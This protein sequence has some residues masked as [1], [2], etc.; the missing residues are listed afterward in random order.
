LKLLAAGGIILGLGSLGGFRFLI[1]D[2]RHL[3]LAQLASGQTTGGSWSL[4]QNTTVLAIHAAITSTG[5]ILYIAGS[6]WCVNNAT[7][8]YTARLL[9]PVTGS[10]TNVTGQ[11]SDLFC[12]GLTH[13]SNGN[14]FICGGTKLYDVDVSSCNGKWH[15]ANSAYEFDIPSGS[16][17]QQGIQ[18]MAQGRWYPTCVTL[19]N[20]KVLIVGGDDDYGDQNYITE[21]YDPSTKSI[22]ISYDPTSNNT[23]CVG[24]IETSS[25]PG[26]GKPCYGGPNQG[27]GPWLSL[28][29]RMH[30]MPS[31]LVF[32]AGPTQDTYL[33]DQFNGSWTHVN[34]TLQFRDYGTTFLLPLQ[35]TTTERGKVMIV[36]GSSTDTTTATNVVEMED[37]NQGTSTNPVLRTVSSITYA[38]KYPLPIIL[39]DGK[40]VIF[41]GSSQGTTN[42][43]LIP[44]MF[45]PENESAG[46]VALPAATVPR[47]YHGMGMLLPDGSVWTA[48]S[49]QASCSTEY[50]TEIFK[51]AYF[52]STRPTI[53]GAPTVGGYGQSIT[54]PTPDA[55]S[56]TRVSLLRLAA[57]THHYDANARLIWLQITGRTSS[58][59]T[60]SA[61]INA[62]LAPPGYYMIYVLN[63]S[64]LVPSVAKIIQIPGSAGGGSTTPPGQ[65]TGLTVTPVSGTY[66]LNLAWTANA[67]TDN[68]I[69]YNVYRST[70]SGFTVN[71]ATD[72]P[73]A[74]PATNS[75]SDAGLTTSTTYYYRVAAVNS[76]GIIGPVSSQASGTTVA[77][78]TI[79]NVQITSPANGATLPSGN[80]LVQGTASDDPGGSGINNVSVRYDVDA[81][82][83]PYATATPSAPGNWSTWSI[84]L[85]ITTAGSHTILA[86]ATDNSGNQQWYEIT[87]TT[88][89]GGTTAPGQVTGLAVTPVSSTQLNLAWTAN[90]STDNVT[91]Y[92]VYRS[93]TSGF[94]VNTATDTPIA[95]PA[96]N[97][98]S[99]AGLTAST[100]YYYR[101]AAVNSSGVIGT[102]SNI[103][104]GTT[105]GTTPPPDTTAPTVTITSP[106]SG[107]SLP[108]GS[109]LVK[110]TAADNTGGSGVN[111]V[112]V[113]VDAGALATATPFAPGNWS[114][115]SVTVTITTTGQH[116]IVAKATDNAGNT[117]SS[118]QVPIK[119][120]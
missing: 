2:K 104:S 96:T 66:K 113:Q 71:T 88:T 54:I 10:E 33:W 11:N 107:S 20:G 111:T 94:T 103:A 51:P 41:A 59:I 6:G 116:K 68:V 63:G 26:A 90:A 118:S 21:I 86:R 30:L 45:D 37:F 75:Y 43:I 5:K 14:I 89:S 112:Q 69:R 91:K 67:S 77:D 87:I 49:T 95:Q 39:P 50:R 100:T 55:A 97:S 101:V 28:Y 79:P 34:V 93:T 47:V 61:P 52:S 35:N 23:Y 119:V 58:S 92:N 106:K 18:Q 78:T 65:V 4:G 32:H 85:N 72:T 46:W 81:N 7:G 29:P 82:I 80:I 12:C 27:T 24:S 53:S 102:P 83:V 64:P 17:I 9:D 40:L 98:Y 74:Q 70:T 13:L 16:L 99:D 60:V 115:W 3:Q 8:P 120:T 109:I 31:G 117:A 19:P 108:H 36:G 114:T 48:S 56:I 38:R 25:C 15:G 22:S 84:T 42:P 105:S 76:S 73:I 110:G 57:T 62:N 44:E 1:D